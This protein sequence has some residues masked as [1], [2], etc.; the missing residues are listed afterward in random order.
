M[1]MIINIPKVVVDEIIYD[2]YGDIDFEELGA[3]MYGI[4]L[5]GEIV[6]EDK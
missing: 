1:K 3:I 2:D 6:K 5:N 4:L